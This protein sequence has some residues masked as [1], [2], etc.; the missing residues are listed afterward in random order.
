MVCYFMFETLEG[1]SEK[2]EI[3]PLPSY[4]NPWYV[5][6]GCLDSPDTQEDD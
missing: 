5:D 1:I 2:N 6:E 3:M 4:E